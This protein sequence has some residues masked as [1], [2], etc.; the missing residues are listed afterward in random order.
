MITVERDT[1]IP[2]VSQALGIIQ[3]HNDIMPVFLDFDKIVMYVNHFLLKQKRIGDPLFDML[4]WKPTYQVTLDTALV[5]WL[6]KTD[7]L[8][9]FEFNSKGVSLADSSFDLKVNLSTLFVARIA[10]S[11]RE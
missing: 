4:G 8:Y 10:V 11:I 6:R 9:G 7:N 1:P 5:N 2:S 3:A